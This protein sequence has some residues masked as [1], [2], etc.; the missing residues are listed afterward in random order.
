MCGI[1]GYVG[2]GDICKTLYQGLKSLEYRGYDSAGVAVIGNSISFVKDAGTVDQVLSDLKLPARKAGIAHTR[3]AT[4]GRPNQLNS[5]PH[6]DEKKKVA[7]T[8]NGIIE[9]YRKLKEELQKRGHVFRSQTDTEVI[10]H[11]IDENLHL[12]EFE[13]FKKAVSMLKGSYAIAAIIDGS[14]RVYFARRFSPL[15]LGVNGDYFLASDVVAFLRWTK[16]AVFI[17]DGEIGYIDEMGFHIEKDGVKVNRK[18]T[19]IQ[20]NFEEAAKDGYDHFMLKEI[21]EQPKVI[22]QTLSSERFKGLATH[23]STL[24]KLVVTS[25]GTSSYAGLA[26][27]YI[28]QLPID[29]I[30]ASEFPALYR[31]GE[32]LAISQSGETADTMTAIR[33]A[34][35]L[36]AQVDAL[37]NVVGS[38]LTR[39]A[40]K[41]IYTH[42]GPEIGVAATKT[43]TSQLA[44]LYALNSYMRGTEIPKIDVK[45]GLA[46]NKDLKKLAMD[47]SKSKS[48]FYLGRG[49]NY[50]TA[51]EGALK[52]KE[53]AYIHAEA[54]QGG[55]MKHGPLALI[56]EGVPVVVINPQDS[57]RKK[58][59]GNIEEVKSR[60][61]FVIGFGEEGDDEMRAL[62][63]VFYGL[64]KTEV[65]PITYTVPLQLLAYHT[66][67]VLGRNPD[68]PRNL[69][70]SVTVE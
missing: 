11:L 42:A 55:E 29:T 16:K 64:P 7:V 53:I 65:S 19:T 34:K 37:V 3:W 39:I 66:A 1:F 18:P 35:S 17:E 63:N 58:M 49:Q 51:L 28:S 22:K 21:F 50:V 59:L 26:F 52:L 8:H 33:Y 43:F 62:S 32:I 2:S 25:A 13:A 69:A 24:D 56:E 61:A 60:G 15:V 48:M 44:A 40:D 47:I 27:K 9:N 20:W 41:T 6:F 46:L 70:K 31:G 68:K 5:H 4:H 57:Y 38:T 12:G 67:V 45:P 14:E 10:P 54:Y 36:G 30:T 23:L